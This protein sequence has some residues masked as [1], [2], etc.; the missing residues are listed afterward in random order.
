M[1]EDEPKK[2]E[3][4]DHNIIVNLQPKEVTHWVLVISRDRLKGYIVLIVLV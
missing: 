4:K 3:Y 2:N 1:R